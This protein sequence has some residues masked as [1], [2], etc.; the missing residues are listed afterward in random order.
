MEPLTRNLNSIAS[1]SKNHV[2]LLTSLKRVKVSNLLFADDCL[3]FARA[4]PKAAGYVNKVLSKFAAAS[5][6]KINLDKS[7]LYFSKNTST[8]TRTNLFNILGI[9]HKSTIGKYLE[10]NNIVFWNDPSNTKDLLLKISNRLGGWKKATLSRA[11]RK[12]KDKETIE[13]CILL[14][15]KLW[16]ARNNYIFRGCTPNPNFVVHAAASSGNDY[17]SHNPTAGGY[18]TNSNGSAIPASS[19]IKWL[20]PPCNLVLSATTR[21][22]LLVLI[23]MVCSMLYAMTS[24]ESKFS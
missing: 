17:R 22:L 5:G 6:Q 10:I 19:F 8:A 21:R 24:G 12:E 9:K 23:E 11:G 4:S 2:G 15:W 20:P 1:R 16:E 7:S 3:I 14:C 13:N 18:K